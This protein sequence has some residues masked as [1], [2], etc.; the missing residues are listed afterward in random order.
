[1]H[2]RCGYESAFASGGIFSSI[3]IMKLI[4]GKY[5]G[6]YYYHIQLIECSNGQIPI[7]LKDK[8]ILYLVRCFGNGCSLFFITDPFA[9]K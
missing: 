6:V 5:E 9:E 3:P 4:K 1:M 2:F 7:I 8:S